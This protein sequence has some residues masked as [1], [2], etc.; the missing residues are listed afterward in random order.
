M[1]G[2]WIMGG[3]DQPVGEGVRDQPAGEGVLAIQDV[4]EERMIQI[5]AEA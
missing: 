3:Q 4:V 2:E 5:V 1:E